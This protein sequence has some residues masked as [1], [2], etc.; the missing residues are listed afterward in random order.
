MF[1]CPQKIWCSLHKQGGCCGIESE[2][3]GTIL[4]MVA[5]GFSHWSGNIRNL[6]SIMS[7]GTDSV[8]SHIVIEMSDKE[9][10]SLFSLSLWH[11][12]LQSLHN[13]F[14]KVW[15]TLKNSFRI[16]IIT[17]AWVKLYGW[18]SV[19]TFD[20]IKWCYGLKSQHLT[21]CIALHGTVPH[22]WS[23]MMII[24]S[25]F[26]ETNTELPNCDSSPWQQCKQSSKGE[27]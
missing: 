27:Q 13:W 17:H 3:K 18:C 20:G 9:G 22:V 14:N 23:C 4:L 2:K 7:M 8:F 24:F 12:C 15:Y 16:G 26:P 21:I 10:T 6:M 11:C 19:C 25:R 5:W 1:V